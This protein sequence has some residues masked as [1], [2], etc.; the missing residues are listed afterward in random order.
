MVLAAL[1]F[2][3]GES[4]D[5]TNLTYPPSPLAGIW[6]LRIIFTSFKE[7]YKA[8]VSSPFLRTSDC[9]EVVDWFNVSKSI[10]FWHHKMA[11]TLQRVQ[12]ISFD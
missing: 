3:D 8:N 11:W 9:R 4:I 6:L 7:P 10:P 2:L 1:V 5:T 12:A